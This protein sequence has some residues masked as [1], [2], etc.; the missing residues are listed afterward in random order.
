LEETIIST[1]GRRDSLQTEWRQKTL[2][3]GSI[4]GKNAGK[5]KTT[6]K[7]QVERQGG[8]HLKNG[9]AKATTR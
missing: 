8:K 5:N 6:G 1:L 2:E 3:I 4:K 9:R 7:R